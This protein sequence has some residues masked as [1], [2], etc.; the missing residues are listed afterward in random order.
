MS[1]SDRRKHPRV[2]LNLAATLGV[3]VPEATF[4]P[5]VHEA[6]VLDLSERGA[7]IRSMLSADTYRELL[8]NPRYCRIS[9]TDEPDLPQRL[10]GKAVYFQPITHPGMP[11]EYRI[12]L[13]FEEIAEADQ[14]RIR[15]YI[16]KKLAEQDAI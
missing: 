1:Q 8:H 2:K 12:G 11:T 6:T 15:A 10:I 16:E 3:M 14:T 5:R 13:F 4:Q 9:L 7:M